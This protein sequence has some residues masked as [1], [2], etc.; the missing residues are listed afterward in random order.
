[1]TGRDGVHQ[2]GQT[3][4]LEVATLA[5][6]ALGPLRWLLRTGLCNSPSWSSSGDSLLYMNASDPN[7][8]FG[9]WYIANAGGAHPGAPRRVTDSSVDLDAT[10]AAAWSSR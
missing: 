1:V 4:D 7:G 3:A 2:L 8:N 9:L 10:L 5:G 6:N